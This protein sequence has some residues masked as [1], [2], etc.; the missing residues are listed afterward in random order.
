MA[1][2][3]PNSTIPIFSA[4]HTQ[5]T[6]SIYFVLDPQP[7]T[8]PQVSRRRGYYGQHYHHHCGV[9]GAGNCTANGPRGQHTGPLTP[10]RPFYS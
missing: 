7:S 3:F 9:A 1:Q 6:E 8:A 5:I 2:Y 4:T 10:Y